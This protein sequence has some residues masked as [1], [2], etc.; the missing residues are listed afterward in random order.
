MTLSIIIS[1]LDSHEVVRRQQ[2]HFA[3]IDP[4]GKAELIIIDDGSDPPLGLDYETNNK[5]SWTW[6]AARNFGARIANG[7]HLLM[8]DIDYILTQEALNFALEFDGD[9]MFFVRQFGILNKD[10]HLRT[11]KKTLL[12][13]GLKEKHLTSTNFWK[14]HRNNFV[15]RKSLFEEMGGYNE[16]IAPYSQIDGP[17]SSFKRVWNRFLR[18]GK[19]DDYTGYRPTLYIFPNGRFCEKDSGL[20]HK[21]SRK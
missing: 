13:Y 18:E 9:R 12:E 6:P 16:E 15:I 11:D 7:T 20:F 4:T 8:M 17:D 2:K 21:L 1:V 3:E 5:Q 14:G 19:A 10:G